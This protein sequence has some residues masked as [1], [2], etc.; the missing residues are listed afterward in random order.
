MSLSDGGEVGFVGAD[1]GIRATLE[2]REVDMMESPSPP[3]KTA[4]GLGVSS[5]G[6]CTG[7][8][9]VGECGR[10]RERVIATREWSMVVLSKMFQLSSSSSSLRVLDKG[11]RHHECSFARAAGTRRTA[12]FGASRRPIPAQCNQ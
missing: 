11:G 4:D 8:S 6:E 7:E 12:C 1:G 9:S 3:L 5:L 2:G 10:N